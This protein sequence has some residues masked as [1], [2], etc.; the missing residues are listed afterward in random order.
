MEKLTQEEL[1]QINDIQKNFSI[2]I[3]QL[4]EAEVKKKNLLIYLEQVEKEKEDIF[5]SLNKQQSYEDELLANIK[6][7]YKGK[8]INF[9]TGEIS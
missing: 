9:D 8:T 6:E 1:I 2:L 5:S 3:Y 4:G 7:K